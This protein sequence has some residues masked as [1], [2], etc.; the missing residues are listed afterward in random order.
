MMCVRRGFTLIELCIVLVILGIIG[1][2]VTLAFRVPVMSIGD[3]PVA[4]ALEARRV[5]LRDGRP[6]TVD[7]V[8]DSGVRSVTAYPDG[9][10]VADTN[11]AIARIDVVER[12]RRQ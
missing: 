9:I 6:Y 7:I 1:S 8:T 5:A 2:I 4:K 3:D 11:I 10:I 12:K